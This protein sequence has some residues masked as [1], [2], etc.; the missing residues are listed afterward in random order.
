VGLSTSNCRPVELTF[1]LVARADVQQADVYAAIAEYNDLGQE[2]FL[3][4]Y[5]MDPLLPRQALPRSR[6]VVDVRETELPRSCQR[7]HPPPPSK[8]TGKLNASCR[9]GIWL[10]QG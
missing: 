3:E 9:T 10:V 2:G 8:N 6:L 5:K 4:K 7:R 1:G